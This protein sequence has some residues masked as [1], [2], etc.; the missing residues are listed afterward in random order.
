MDLKNSIKVVETVSV[1]LSQTQK[2]DLAYRLTI[3]SEEGLNSYL[4]EMLGEG[5]EEQVKAVQ[6]IAEEAKT[7]INPVVGL[8]LR[9]I[10][11]NKGKYSEKGRRKEALMAEILEIIQGEAK[12][13]A[14]AA[15]AARKANQAKK[16]EGV[17]V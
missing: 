13:R 1:N 12:A 7:L 15:A 6:R 14:E 11:K 16:A 8:A 5:Q 4:K 17:V 3:N 9:T 10:P 2:R